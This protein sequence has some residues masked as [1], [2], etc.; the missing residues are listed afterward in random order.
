MADFENRYQ[1]ALVV[2]FIKNSIRALS[3]PMPFASR[4]LHATGRPRIAFEECNALDNPL[5]ILLAADSLEF[6]DGRGFYL[7]LIACHGA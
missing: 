6:L 7:Q 1:P 2:D 5:S 3:N 4:E